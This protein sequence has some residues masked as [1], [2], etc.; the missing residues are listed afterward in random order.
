[1]VY[2]KYMIFINNLKKDKKKEQCKIMYEYLKEKCWTQSLK[3]PNNREYFTGC[4]VDLKCMHSKSQFNHYCFD[5]YPD[6][7]F[8]KHT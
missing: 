3:L 2:F 4:T 6:S 5:L 1:M 8:K 7:H